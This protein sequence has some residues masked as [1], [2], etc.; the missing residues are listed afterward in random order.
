MGGVTRA[1]TRPGRAIAAATLLL[2]MAGSACGAEKAAAPEPAQPSSATPAHALP[3]PL[4]LAHPAEPAT[5][6]TDR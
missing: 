6:A 1:R 3:V 4:S 5:R 2:L